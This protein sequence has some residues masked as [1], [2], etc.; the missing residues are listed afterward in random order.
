MIQN[1]F[2]NSIVDKMMAAETRGRG[3][4]ELVMMVWCSNDT[5]F[6]FAFSS[7]Q[8]VFCL[9]YTMRNQFGQ[10][11]IFT[12]CAKWMKL[13]WS[14]ISSI[15]AWMVINGIQWWMK[16]G[17]YKDVLAACRLAT[18]A[19]SAL[20]LSLDESFSSLI[21][22]AKHFA[23]HLYAMRTTI[24]SINKIKTLREL[25]I[26]EVM[27]LLYIESIERNHWQYHIHTATAH[28]NEV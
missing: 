2:I 13:K 3:K 1:S 21:S 9:T 4:I 24:Y 11:W 19:N 26:Q 25:E 6:P 27:L 5:A 18:N 17:F 10:L 22:G 15:V 14:W 28:K 7:Y 16:L 8:I 23:A 20:S 12:R